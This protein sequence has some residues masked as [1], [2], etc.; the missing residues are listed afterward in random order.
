MVQDLDTGFV[1]P[2]SPSPTGEAVNGGAGSSSGSTRRSISVELRGEAGLGRAPAAAYTRFCRDRGRRRAVRRRGQA[3]GRVL[4]TRRRASNARGRLRVRPRREPARDR[5]RQ[6]GDIGSTAR[7]Y[8][9]AFLEPRDGDPPL[10]DALTVNAYLGGDSVEPF[11]G[12]CRRHGAG[13]FCLVRTSNAGAADVQDVSAS[14]GRTLWQ[15]VAELVASGAPSQR[16]SAWGRSSGDIPGGRRGAPHAER[17]L[18]LPGSARRG[19]RPPTSRVRSRAGRQT[20]RHGL[21]L[22]H[23][24]PP[25]R[26]PTG[27]R[28]RARQAARLASE[29]WAASGW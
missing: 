1:S 17:S 18:L 4:R 13:I 11:L 22:D 6:R 3:A 2:P 25:A 29:V 19:H 28:R 14:D 5:R 20:R 23:L 21:A 12:A 10:A 9:A 16:G 24:R 7:A 15:H 27:G 26:M 8:S